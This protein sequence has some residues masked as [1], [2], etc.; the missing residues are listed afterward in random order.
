MNRQLLREISY[1]GG[2]CA[3]IAHQLGLRKAS[4]AAS[5]VSVGLLSASFLAP[6]YRFKG[7][8]ALITGGSRGLGLSIAWNLLHQGAE[9]ALVARD[10][11]ELERAQQK[12]R[13]DFPESRIWTVT[14]DITNPETLPPCFKD[15]VD[16]MGGLDL[17]VNNAGSILVGPLSTMDL[18][19]YSR[20][21]ELHLMAAI[22]AI[23][24]ATP[25]L[26]R[27]QG[28]IL[29]ISSLGGKRGIP[30][31]AAYNA[32]KFALT[33]YAQ[34]AAAELA[35][36][37]I[38]MTTVHPTV[39]R[40][41]S[42]IQAYFKGDAL[43]EYEV[44]AAMDVAPGL[45]MSADAAAKKILGAVADGRSEMILS[46]VGNLQ[47][48]FGALFPEVVASG[49]RAAARALPQGSVR[50]AIQGKDLKL[51]ADNAAEALLETRSRKFKEEYN[52]A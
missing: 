47:Q 6:G 1:L 44:F 38:V 51:N 45:S 22:R 29:N 46:L 27:S 10:A 5:L 18:A 2:T 35:A 21:T 33:G 32:S 13:K 16:L 39:M 48:V 26:A 24:F 30:H 15:V 20:L 8:R 19:D 42:P 9:V 23:E 28:R 11:E 3:V 25:H 31:M 4:Q 41:G 12:L 40:T 7:K 17:L 14:C 52:Q 34:S 36:D 43:K 50:T 49:L 37:G